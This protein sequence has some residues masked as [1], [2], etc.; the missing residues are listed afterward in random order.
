MVVVCPLQRGPAADGKEGRQGWRLCMKVNMQKATTVGKG[1]LGCRMEWSSW[2][3]LSLSTSLRSHESWL[4]LGR[5]DGKGS[6]AVFFFFPSF[7]FLL[8]PGLSAHPLVGLLLFSQT[9]SGCQMAFYLWRRSSPS[10]WAVPIALIPLQ[11]SLL[12]QRETPAW[13]GA[14]SPL[15]WLEEG[16]SWS[17]Q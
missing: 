13:S 10:A 4:R 11:L 9:T 12:S 14:L 1:R 16:G 15:Y 7:F 2:C 3:N 5:E 6:W 17:C 8:F